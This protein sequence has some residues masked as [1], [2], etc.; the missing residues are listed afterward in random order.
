MHC[1]RSL[2]TDFS[3][4]RDIIRIN[5]LCDSYFFLYCCF[6]IVGVCERNSSG[7]L[8]TRV[9]SASES[10]GAAG[11]AVAWITN[12]KPVSCVARSNSSCHS[13][14]S[15]GVIEC[16]ANAAIYVIV[17]KINILSSKGW[18]GGSYFSDFSSGNTN[19]IA[20]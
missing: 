8:C 14:T 12:T 9:N 15:L 10:Y 6:S 13:S 2:C 11:I 18:V 3:D 1:A 20:C 17:F 16:I 5:C 19:L 4:C 7:S